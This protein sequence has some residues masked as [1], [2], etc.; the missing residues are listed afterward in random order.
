[1]NGFLGINYKLETQKA[2]PRG[3]GVCLRRLY[4]E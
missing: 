4:K 2:I 1:F 3:D